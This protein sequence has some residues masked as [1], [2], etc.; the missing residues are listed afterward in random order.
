MTKK[1]TVCISSIFGDILGIE[2]DIFS[3]CILNIL[4]IEWDISP[5]LSIL[6]FSTGGLSNRLRA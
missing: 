6:F 5:R 1:F 4:G 3:V 2:W